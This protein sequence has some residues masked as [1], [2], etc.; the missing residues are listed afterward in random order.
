MIL[1][2]P[3]EHRITAETDHLAAPILDLVDQAGV[4]GVEDLGEAVG[5]AA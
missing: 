4:D 5:A 3:T 1:R 2:K